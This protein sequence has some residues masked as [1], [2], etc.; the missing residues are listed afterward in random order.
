MNMRPY[1]NETDYWRI[2]RFLQETFPLN[3]GQERN[4]HVARLDYWRWH[5][6]ANCGLCEPIDDVTFLWITD[7]KHIKAVLHRFLGPEVAI[8]IHPKYK[9][10]KLEEE[11]I[12][13]AEKKLSRASTD[14][15]RKIVIPSFDDDITRK[16]ILQKRGYLQS[17]APVNHWWRDLNDPVPMPAIP[18]GYT[19]RSMGRA[20]D[21]PS[22][23][24]AS[25]T[26]F[27][28]NDPDE[29]YDGWYWYLNI[30]SAPLYRR[31]LDIVA[32]ASDG[33][34]ASFC[35][36]YYDQPTQS[37]VCVLVG[38]AADHQ[39]QGLGRAVIREGLRRLKALG[40]ARVFANAYDAPSDGLYRSVLGKCMLSEYWKKTFR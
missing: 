5:F 6:I 38:T 17:G 11:T 33:T 15:R 40:A 28:P 34:I 32:A 22:R 10:E 39:R 18:N 19:I 25:W 27:H 3:E 8:H 23:S 24:W 36:I 2:R 12:T 1:N 13:L 14:G 35:T 21:I 7:D 30:M 29:S 31:D 37:A 16:T 26:A 9:T 4:W 20:D